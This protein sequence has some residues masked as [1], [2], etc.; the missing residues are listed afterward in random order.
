VHAILLHVDSPGGE[1]S[2]IAEFADRLFAARSQKP[3]TAY[4]SDL[5][6]SAGYWLASA[7]DQVVVAET[8]ALG[9][10]GVVMAVR[11]PQAQK[12][13]EIEFVSSQSPN[14]RPNPGTESGKAQYQS[15]VDALGDVFVGAVARN[16]GVDPEIV[17]SDFGGGGLFIG[18][19]AVD[20]GLADTVGSFE[21]TLRD[22]AE[23]TAQAPAAPPARPA[24]PGRKHAMGMREK[25]FAWLDGIEAEASSDQE[26]A[27]VS[28]TQNPP[29]LPAPSSKPAASA[30]DGELQRVR[31]E[32][33]ASQAE[34]ERLKIAR[35]QDLAA[36]FAAQSIGAEKAFP[37]EREALIAVYVQAALDDAKAGDGANRVSL[38]EA[39][40]AVRPAH[41]LT[42]E[43][44][45]PAAL[46]I[47]RQQETTAK[48]PNAEPSPE[49]VN[50]LL[51]KTALG[52]SIVN[53]RGN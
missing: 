33:R 2:G 41:A 6:A 8:A 43:Q 3:I 26:A 15:L 9:S 36:S 50:E 49:R 35:I 53:G 21:Q 34:A 52:A 40:Y 25:F 30:D 42:R 51:S 13:K 14:K 28:D 37:I 44:L 7:A 1:V 48:D 27:I 18:Q 12:A 5:G 4:V 38:L 47:L 20:A 24:G 39:V 31:A 23:Q 17:L 46:Q 19:Q 22:L 16:R 11:D 10:I 45:N 29:A 32:L